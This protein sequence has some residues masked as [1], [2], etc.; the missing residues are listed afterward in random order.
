VT[1]QHG[2]TLLAEC[3]V[4]GDKTKRTYAAED[5]IYHS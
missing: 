3:S 5:I 4:A 2:T 1:Q